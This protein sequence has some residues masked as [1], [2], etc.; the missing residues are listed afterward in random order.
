[1]LDLV[2]NCSNNLDT[3]ASRSNDSYAFVGKFITFLVIGRMHQLALEVMQSRNIGPLPVVQ[4]TTSIDE[5]LGTVVE[6]FI[7]SKIPYS[8]SPQTGFVVPFHM[9]QTVP[10]FDVFSNEVILALNGL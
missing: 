9:L 5:E 2:L 6:Y 10:Q 3:R 4:H 1:M 8:A 7:S